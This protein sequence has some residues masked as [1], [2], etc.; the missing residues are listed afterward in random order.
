[1]SYF[2]PYN[3]S[4]R[5]NSA[6]YRGQVIRQRPVNYNAITLSQER[7]PQI[8]SY[9]VNNG[10][11]IY[12][13][14][15]PSYDFKLVP[16]SGDG[17]LFQQR[18]N[19]SYTTPSQSSLLFVTL[20]DILDLIPTEMLSGIFDTPFPVKEF[21]F[22]V[23]LHSFWANNMRVQTSTTFN[24]I[25]WNLVTNKY[26]FDADI[27]DSGDDDFNAFENIFFLENKYDTGCQFWERLGASNIRVS[28]ASSE[29]PGYGL[30]RVD[31]TL[32]LPQF[33]SLEIYEGI[34]NRDNSFNFPLLNLSFSAVNNCTITI[35][36]LSIPFS[37][38]FSVEY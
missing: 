12:N 22:R 7:I 36:Q 6:S 17:Q 2:D 28:Q 34:K 1:M 35:N 26:N 5:A 38:Y 31:S 14:G 16:V 9:L 30:A 8:I 19:I 11:T 13:P 25:Q 27:Q 10:Y 29:F 3:V 24:E 32:F 18:L 15:I 23:Q 37:F 33:T 4:T 20:Y 21:Y